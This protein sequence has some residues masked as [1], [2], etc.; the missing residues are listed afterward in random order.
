MVDQSP[1]QFNQAEVKPELKDVKRII[2]DAE[3]LPFDANMFDRWTSA[4]SIEYWPN[5]Q[6]V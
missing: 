6:Q 5:P 2:G 1:H 4:G 3:N